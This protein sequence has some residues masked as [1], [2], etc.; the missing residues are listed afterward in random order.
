M[1][2]EELQSELQKTHEKSF[3][4]DQIYEWMHKR[5]ASS[6]DE[7]TNI[8]KDLRAKLTS[9]YE[10]T[11]FTP[12]KTSVSNDEQTTKYLFGL[13]DGQ[14]IETV[15]MKYHHG[16]SVCISSQVGC[17]MSC[18]FCA[19]GIDGFVRNLTA[20][21]MLEQIYAVSRLIGE[22]ISNVVVMGTGEPLDN[23]KNLLRMIRMLT[24]E[25]GLNI[26]QRNITVSTC[27]IVSA[28]YELAQENLQITL[29]VSLHGATDEIRQRL[30]P[31]AKRYDLAQLQDAIV[32]YQE[33]TGRRVTLEYT[34][35]K[36]IND[37]PQAAQALARFA[38]DLRAHVNL[39]LVNPVKELGLT[40]PTAKG[41]RAFQNILEK[42]RIHVTMRREMGTEV[43][44][45]CGQLRRQ[46][47]LRQ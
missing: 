33:Q 29:A 36:G 14:A 18:A 25:R 5:L 40:R 16:N 17:K 37:T 4:A 38:K 39:I 3:R 9:D 6:I 44:A 26:S 23:L 30:M 21:E 27:G 46:E 47:L 19:S 43:N 28:L 11:H 1:N 34:L 35:V 20:A 12:L 32:T 31:V 13:C 2:I 10:Y 22:R 45:S 8:S 41:A 42:N 15:L 7:M 24:D